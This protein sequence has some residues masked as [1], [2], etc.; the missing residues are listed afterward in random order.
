MNRLTV[1]VMAALMLLGSV[2]IVPLNVR[3]EGNMLIPDTWIDSDFNTNFTGW[4]P[5]GAPPLVVTSGT[6]YDGAGAL[7]LYAQYSGQAAYY[8]VPSIR[9]YSVKLYWWQASGSTVDIISCEKNDGTVVGPLI[10]SRVNGS[11]YYGTGQTYYGTYALETWHSIDIVCQNLKYKFTVDYHTDPDHWDFSD[12]SPVV[13]VA[14]GANDNV[15]KIFVRN[16][17]ADKTVVFDEIFVQER[18]I[19]WDLV[20]NVVVPFDTTSSDSIV[21]ANGMVLIFIIIG[22]AMILGTIVGRIGFILGLCVTALLY[23]MTDPNFLAY[24][25]MIWGSSAITFWRSSLWIS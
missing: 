2:A 10:Q 9:N 17:V 3:A 14:G 20:Q 21:S 25:A 18:W 19:G 8:A 12:W 13:T 24:A 7:L 1:A 15:Q 16:G 11:I 5:T 22:P 6:K 23:L 4:N